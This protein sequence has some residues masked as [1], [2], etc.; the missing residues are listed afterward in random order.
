MVRVVR[1]DAGPGTV[2][3][4]IDA[5]TIDAAGLEG[6]DGACTSRAR[7]S[8]RSAGP[9]S[10][11][12]RSSRAAPRARPSSSTRSTSLTDKPPVLV[13][14]SAIG[15]YGNRGDEQ[16]T[17]TSERGEGF[18]ADVVTAWEAAAEPAAAAGIRVPRIR[19]GIVLVTH[20][21]RAPAARR[22]G[23]LR[24]PRQ[25]RL[26]PP[27]DELDQP[28]RRGRCDPVPAGARHRRPR[29]P[30][31]AEPGHQRGLHQDPRPGAAPTDVPARPAL[32]SEAARRRRSSPRRCSTTGSACS[33]TSC[34]TPATSS[35]TPT[36]RRPST[37]SSGG[38]RVQE[39]ASSANVLRPAVQV[40]SA[41]CGRRRRR[42]SSPR[43]CSCSTAARGPSTRTRRRCPGG[44]GT[45]RRASASP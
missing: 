15:F 24:P 2:R 40:T 27:V 34:S 5:G 20:G 25:A 3:W 23:A 45:A 35:G 8:A 28:G 39:S 21:R 42:G 16:L 9:T 6:L 22:P 41:A 17:E 38:S 13:S 26:R 10:R 36:W 32:R 14:G 30:H 33:P 1:S 29:E 4:D 43:S 31:G 37:S 11:S 19:T 12:A 44:P 18:L 7:G